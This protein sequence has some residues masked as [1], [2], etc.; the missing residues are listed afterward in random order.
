MLNVK[1]LIGA[2]NCDCEIFANLR[3]TFVSSSGVYIDPDLA[4]GLQCVRYDEY[5]MRQGHVMNSQ[6]PHPP[7]PAAR[8]GKTGRE[9]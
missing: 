3:L 5:T 2:F 1:A 7:P 6:T 8:P 9:I 4:G